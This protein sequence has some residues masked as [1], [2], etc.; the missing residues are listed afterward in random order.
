MRI[1]T[2]LGTNDSGTKADVIFVFGDLK[3]PQKQFLLYFIPRWIKTP[4]ED[5]HTHHPGHQ[6]F[7]GPNPMP[8]SYLATSKTPRNNLA[9]IIYQVEWKLPKK[10][11]IPTILGTNDS[12]TKADVIF[13]FATSETPEIIFSLFYTKMNENS[14]RRYINR[15]SWAR[16]IPKPM[17]MSY[18]CSTTSKTQKN[19][20]RFILYQDK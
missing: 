10:V 12:G 19:D 9:S 5:A 18:S 3:N 8:Y 14:R 1:P 16:I 20:F 17:L 7:I 2:I 15:P 6:V 11:H 13:V 4:E